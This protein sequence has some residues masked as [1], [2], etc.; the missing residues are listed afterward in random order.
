VGGVQLLRGRRLHAPRVEE[1]RHLVDRVAIERHPADRRRRH[2]DEQ[3]VDV[4]EV[5]VEAV[6]VEPPLVAA[7]DVARRLYRRRRKGVGELRRI[8]AQNCGAE[9]R[10]TVLSLCF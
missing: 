8:A 1:A 5:E 6:L 7:D 2:P 4:D 9:L 10:R 3:V